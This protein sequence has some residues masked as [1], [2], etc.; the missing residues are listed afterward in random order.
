[1]FLIVK[2]MPTF[3]AILID[4]LFLLLFVTYLILLFKLVVVNIDDIYFQ[5][6]FFFFLFVRLCNLL[7]LLYFFNTRNTV[8][9][10]I[11]L[12]VWLLIL[13]WIFKFGI[14]V[15][16]NL[17]FKL[18]IADSLVH[19]LFAILYLI[20]IIHVLFVLLKVNFNLFRLMLFLI[21]CYFAFL[22][23]LNVN[24]KLSRL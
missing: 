11:C 1:M 24:L 20:P 9:L 4:Y 13:L 7:I 5:T 6:E 2:I 23:I 14:A 12:V 16:F 21:I 22:I 17:L 3:I 19:S 8:S 15:S 10:T 18:L